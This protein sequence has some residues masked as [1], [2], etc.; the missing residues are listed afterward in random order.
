L[1]RCAAAK[2][3][4]GEDEVELL[5][6]Q[7]VAQVRRDVHLDL[8]RQARIGLGHPLDEA[9]QPGV[10]DGLGD[11]EPQGAADRR[12]VGHRMEHLRPELQ[13]AFR[14]VEHPPS[15]IGRHH[16]ALLPHQQFLADL[17]LQ[18]GNALRDGRL[19]GVQLHRRAVEAPESGDPDQGLECLEVHHAVVNR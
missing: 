4:E 11:A 5:R 19:G 6:H 3:P 7:P 10:D 2:C 17:R 12:A 15:R 9:R 13:Q 18:L 8:Q 16:G 14:I 1:R